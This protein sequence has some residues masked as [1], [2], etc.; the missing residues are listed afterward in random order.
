MIWLFARSQLFSIFCINF[1]KIDV[2]RFPWDA[3]QEGEA[4][5]TDADLKIG[6][7]LFLQTKKDVPCVP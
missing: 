2:I 5:D 4:T 3:E 1:S 6:T 7:Q